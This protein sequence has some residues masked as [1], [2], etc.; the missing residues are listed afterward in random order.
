MRFNYCFEFV[1][2]LNAFCALNSA[3]SR[4]LLPAAASAATSA[5]SSLRSL[6]HAVYLLSALCCC[7][8]GFCC[9]CWLR[10][11]LCYSGFFLVTRFSFGFFSGFISAATGT[12][13]WG[14]RQNF[15][16]SFTHMEKRRTDGRRTTDASRFLFV[17]V[18]LSLALSRYPRS[19][20]LLLLNTPRTHTHQSNSLWPDFSAFNPHTK[21]RVSYNIFWALARVL[22][23]LS[24]CCYTTHSGALTDTVV[25]VAALAPH[26]QPFRSRIARSLRDVSVSRG[27][28]TPGQANNFIR[29]AR[30][31]LALSRSPLHCDCMR[32]RPIHRQL[33]ER[34]PALG[35]LSL[36][37]LSLLSRLRPFWFEYALCEGRLK[38]IHKVME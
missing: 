6:S 7:C 33:R 28:G 14:I 9:D 5:A 31:P 12:I 19:R 20:R 8:L 23:Y 34:S 16:T 35:S 1:F 36:G 3:F 22:R 30:A 2:C 15:H 38:C 29:R 26:S 4:S 18:L 17:V 11:F 32:G 27:C 10:F 37:A 25:V 24:C 21:L 13:C